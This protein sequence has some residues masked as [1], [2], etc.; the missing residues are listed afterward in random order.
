[1]S[2]IPDLRS[3]QAG[4]LESG[5]IMIAVVPGAPGSGIAVQLES[6][7]RAQY[8]KAIEAT[9]RLTTAQYSASDILIKAVDRGALDCTIRAR[10]MAALCRAGAVSAKEGI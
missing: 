2:G 1:M 8:G 7:V 6:I 5:D 4:T 9:I 10:V 3:A